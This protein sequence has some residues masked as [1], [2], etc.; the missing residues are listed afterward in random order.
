MI[1]QNTEKCE[2]TIVPPN[3]NESKKF[4][5]DWEDCPK[6]LNEFADLDD[7]LINVFLEHGNDEMMVKRFYLKEY[8]D[9][10]MRHLFAG[11]EAEILINE[12][13]RN[14]VLK[15]VRHPNQIRKF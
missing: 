8:S 9:G 15:Y 2:R 12:D 5:I 4:T 10:L 6:K 3:L 1:I 13:G 11:G 7:I 14:N